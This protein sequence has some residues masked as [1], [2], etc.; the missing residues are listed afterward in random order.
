MMLCKAL[1]IL[2]TS[3]WRS[4]LRSSG[5]TTE[6]QCL[7]Q[8]CD[9]VLWPPRL[10]LVLLMLQ[11]APRRHLCQCLTESQPA[12]RDS[13]PE[14]CQVSGCWARTPLCG[15]CLLAEGTGHGSTGSPVTPGHWCQSSGTQGTQGTQVMVHLG[16]VLA[17]RSGEKGTWQWGSSAGHSPPGPATGREEALSPF[18]TPGRNLSLPFFFSLRILSKILA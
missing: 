1:T 14:L 5:A 12:V 17:V 16:S 8:Y 18:P 4:H 13:K 15:T 7:S 6:R 11:R 9:F 2:T 3:P 10:T